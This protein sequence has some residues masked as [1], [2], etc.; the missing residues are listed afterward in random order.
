MMVAMA[1]SRVQT[2]SW[3]ADHPSA[4]WSDQS[5]PADMRMSAATGSRRRT[6]RW[7]GVSLR[8]TSRRSMTAETAS[9]RASPAMDSSSVVTSPARGRRGRPATSL[10]SAALSRRA[11]ARCAGL[12]A[13]LDTSSMA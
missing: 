3:S 11:T 13:Y 12:C 10:R 8:G 2:A 6:A 1:S 5:A 9:A 4:F 7:S